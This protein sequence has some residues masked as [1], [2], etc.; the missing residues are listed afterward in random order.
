MI[1]ILHILKYIFYYI[2]FVSLSKT[3]NS[4]YIAGAILITF[5]F[6]NSFLNTSIRRK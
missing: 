2:V 3:Y 6:I 5:I 1:Y 4:Y